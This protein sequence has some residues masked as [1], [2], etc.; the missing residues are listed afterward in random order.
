MRVCE[1]LC[2]Y[3]CVRGSCV[4]ECVYASVGGSVVVCACVNVRVLVAVSV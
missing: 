4:V 1:C 2:G 3:V